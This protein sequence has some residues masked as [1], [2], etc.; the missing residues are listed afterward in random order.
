[1]A[2]RSG[3]AGCPLTGNQAASLFEQNVW[4]TEAGMAALPLGSSRTGSVSSSL[5]AS[6]I[7]FEILTGHRLPVWNGSLRA[8][9]DMTA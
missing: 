8:L 3:V 7:E 6:G 1:M 5:T 2:L 9:I 4:M